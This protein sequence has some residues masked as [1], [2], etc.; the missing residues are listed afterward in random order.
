INSYAALLVE[1]FSFVRIIENDYK[2]SPSCNFSHIVKSFSGLQSKTQIEQTYNKIVQEFNKEDDA[3]G[4]GNPDNRL[5]RQKIKEMK[6][7]AN[8][9][10]LTEIKEDKYYEE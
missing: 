3:K 2:N 5:K 9:S 7:M 6:K 4:T 1:I 8:F 10:L